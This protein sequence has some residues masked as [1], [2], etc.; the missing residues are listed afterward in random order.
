V[1]RAHDMAT[2]PPPCGAEIFL[3]KH[4][5]LT[6]LRDAIPACRGCSLYRD[7]TQPVFGEGPE[8]ARIVIVDE[9][10]GDVEDRTGHPFVGPAGRLLDA[11]LESAG[12]PRSE[13]Y[14]TNA[15]K[16]FKFTRRGKR[17]IHDRPTR[18]EVIACRPWLGAEL[19]V[20]APDIV[21]VCGATAA[22]ALLG[23]AFRITTSRGVVADPTL[24]CWTFA[25]VH[26]AAV[27]RAPDQD[28]RAQARAHL[29]ADFAI[30]GDKF[31]ELPPVRLDHN[32]PAIESRGGSSS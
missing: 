5:T 24:A 23:E 2:H 17:R 12:I 6:A 27:L 19:E 16:H 4:H 13:V 8:T 15:V 3:P 11:A 10:P 30:I 14:V 7:A 26:P 9:Q 21:V 18:N 28:H 20:L 31:R 1:Q 29:L 25:T 32:A 22:R